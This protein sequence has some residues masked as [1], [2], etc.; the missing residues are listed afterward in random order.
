M[1]LMGRAFSEPGHGIDELVLRQFEGLARR[2]FPVFRHHLEDLTEEE[3]YWRVHFM[4]GAMAHTMAAPGRLHFM[5]GGLCS[6]QDP[7]EAVDRLR[8]AFGLDWG[9]RRAQRL[10]ALAASVRTLRRQRGDRST[11]DGGPARVRPP[12]MGRSE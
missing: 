5:S 6:F 9:P 3:F 10:E 2:F 7:E 8:E 12:E 1:L 11:A 4:I